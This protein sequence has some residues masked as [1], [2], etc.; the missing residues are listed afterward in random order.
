MH[1]V[2][3]YYAKKAAITAESSCILYIVNCLLDKGTDPWLMND[4]D[5]NQ[6]NKIIKVNDII[7][8]GNRY[9][10]ETENDTLYLQA[11][12][13]GKMNMEDFYTYNE[14]KNED[15]LQWRTFRFFYDTKLGQ[16]IFGS[17]SNVEWLEPFFRH[18]I[19]AP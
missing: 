1:K 5:F 15:I 9:K 16:P 17:F 6:F 4:S 19:T 14:A 13:A 2:L 11:C 8:Q 7:P 3:I 18:L 12:D 10:L